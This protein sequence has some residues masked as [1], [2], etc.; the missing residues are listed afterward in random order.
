DGSDDRRASFPGNSGVPYLRW[1]DRGPQVEPCQAHQARVARVPVGS[2][3]MSDV[4]VSAN[5]GTTSVRPGFEL[6]G[7]ALTDWM[8]T[9]VP[10]FSGPLAVEQFKGGQSNPTYKLITPARSYVL[11]R[12]PPGQLLK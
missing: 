11:R 1:P 6:D 4:M 5:Q 7:P 10:D 9:H 12:K 2:D 8:E 3:G